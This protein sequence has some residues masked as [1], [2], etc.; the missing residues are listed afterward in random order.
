MLGN[1]PHNSSFYAHLVPWL[2]LKLACSQILRKRQSQEEQNRRKSL[3]ARGRRVSF[4]PDDELETRHLFSIVSPLSN[5]KPINSSSN[6]TQHYLEMQGRLAVLLPASGTP[7]A[8][9]PN[10]GSQSR[11]STCCTHDIALSDNMQWQRA[12]VL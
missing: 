11:R 4:A 8:V 10:S 7:G 1:V 5:G 12:A 3:R 2:N 6:S 9:D